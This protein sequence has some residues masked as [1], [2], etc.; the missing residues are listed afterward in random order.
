MLRKNEQPLNIHQMRTKALSQ[1]SSLIEIALEAFQA[2]RSL[3]VYHFFRKLYRSQIENNA[4]S[5]HLRTSDDT[6][7]VNLYCEKLAA[8]LN[9][10]K[11]L[12]PF[13]DTPCYL[14][15]AR[16]LLGPA[17]PARAVVE[18]ISLMVLSSGY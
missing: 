16:G 18:R 10:E 6:C 1:L 3:G 15:P 9:S 8:A 11:S 4:G 17:A 14:P 12:V 5:R 7:V 2:T 13:G